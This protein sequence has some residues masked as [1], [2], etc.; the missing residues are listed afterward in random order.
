[1]SALLAS[2]LAQGAAASAAARPQKLAASKAAPH[3]HRRRG[4]ATR[5]AAP[6]REQPLMQQLAQQVQEHSGKPSSA[7]PALPALISKEQVVALEAELDQ[8]LSMAAL[9]RFNDNL[10]KVPADRWEE[11]LRPVF[12]ELTFNLE[13]FNPAFTSCLLMVQ[14]TIGA[15]DYVRRDMALKNLIQP[16]A[17]EYGMHNN[18]PQHKTHR[19]L[20]SDFYASLFH[21]PLES[22]IAQGVPPVAAQ[23]LWAKMSTDIM[24][25]GGAYSNPME[26]ASYALGYNLA[27][28]YLADYEKT[29]MLDSF[30]A[31]DKAVFSAQGRQID[32]VF[33]EVHA[34][35][36][37]EHAAIGHN[38]V[39]NFVPE[40]HTQV[41]RQAMKDHDQDFA[42]FYNRLADMLAV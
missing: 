33:L 16:L 28:E 29:W 22:L 15:S 20:F 23:A 30:R 13:S 35:G 19:E 42:A 17:G 11:V 1:M 34:E 9:R 24:T 8:G 3:A 18:Q 32:W 31:L 38:A 6:A 41:M 2:G 10:R 40:E 5:I 26:Q 37:A 39:L 27:I 4:V 21:A 25:G 36:E 14:R 7:Q 12:N